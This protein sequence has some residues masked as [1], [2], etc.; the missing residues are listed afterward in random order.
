MGHDLGQLVQKTVQDILD[1]TM[2]RSIVGSQERELGCPV[3]QQA[4]FV[5]HSKH[6]NQCLNQVCR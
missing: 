2:A 3:D 6:L 4:L 1:Y 5:D